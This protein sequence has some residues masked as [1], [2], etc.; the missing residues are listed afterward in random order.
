MTK[1]SKAG[2]LKLHKAAKSY[3]T[4]ESAKEQYGIDNGYTDELELVFE[5]GVL[6]RDQT[7]KEIRKIA[8]SY[9]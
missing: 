9:L 3:S 8:N 7:F 2:I 6:Y 1:S 5:N 4:I